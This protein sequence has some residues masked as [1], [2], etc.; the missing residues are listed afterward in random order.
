[1]V[2]GRTKP[3][4]QAGKKAALRTAAVVP[5][6]KSSARF[7]PIVGVGASAGGLEALRRLLKALPAN[8]GM[9]FVLVQHLD[10]EHESMLPRL[11][12][13]ATEMPVLEVQDGM[14]MQPNHVYVIPP[15]TTL[16]IQEN[17]LHLMAR[18]DGGGRHMP[19]DHFFRS[20]AENE[21][22][23]AVGVILSGA[24]S[25]GTLGL[26]TIKAEGGI[27]FAQDERTAK[28]DSMPRSAISAGCV[29]FVLPPEGIARELTRIARHPYLGV[30]APSSAV[31]M[32]GQDNEDL[33]KIF[34]LLRSVTG[35]E[36]T[37]YKYATL[38][39][40]IARRMI[41]HKIV[42]LRNY[43]KYLQENRAE[44]TSLYEDILIHV[45]GFFRNP[46]VFQELKESIFPK[47]L[48]GKP[49]GEPVR[50]WVAGCST[51]EEA[52]SL[53]MVLLEYLGDK[54]PPPPVQIF[55]TDISDPA[56]EK[57]R[58]GIYP[59]SSVSDVS[60]ERLRRF[61]I[62]A[63]GGYQIAKSVREMCV[64]ARQDLAKDPPFSRLDLLS[65]RNVL[66]Y[67]E[68]VLQ[69]KV[70]A[71][72]HYALRPNGFLILGKSESIS[73]FAE[74]FLPAGRNK[75]YS[76][77]PAASRPVFDAPPAG[78]ET[79]PAGSVTRAAPPARFDVQKEADRIVVDH[80]A[81][82]G[83]IANE[84]LQILHFRGDVAPF[85]S[86]APGEASLGLLKMVRPEFAVELRTALHQARKQ[87][88]P[89]R[90]DGVLLKRNGHLFK[91]GLEVVPIKGEAGER[92]YLVLFN[93][94]RVP[95]PGPGAA[96]RTKA[97]KEHELE[98]ARVRRELETNKQHLHS[99]IGEQEA[100]NEELQSANEEIL[101]SN[102]ELQSTNEELETAKEELQSTNEELV[103][104]NEQLQNRN[105]ELGQLSDD[106]S[107]LLGG[108]NIPIVMLGNDR[109]IR[110]FTPP[111]EKLLNLL[112]TDLGRPIDNIRPNF[113]AA[114]MEALI[115]AVI[116]EAAPREQ[117]IAD[118]EGK[119]YSMRL[120][121]YRTADNKIDGV[122]MIFVDV[123]DL[124]RTQVALREQT[125]FAEAVMQ[126]AGALVLVTDSGGRIVAFNRAC[127]LSSGYKLAEVKD[128]SIWDSLL[129][130]KDQLEKLREV[131]R[132]IR[133]GGSPLQHESDWAT[134][135]GE[136]RLISWSSA[137]MA[138][139]DG[140]VRY[141]VWIGS[142]ITERRR[143]EALEANQA[144]LR[145]SQRELRALAAGLI[146]AQEQERKRIS[147][148]LHDDVSQKLVALGMEVEG[149]LRKPN[150]PNRQ[151]RNQLVALRDRLMSV[152]GDIRRTAYQ[153]HPSSLD[154]LG[155]AAALKSY[156]REFARQEGILIH[157]GTRNVPRK[158]PP[159]IALSLYRSAQEALRNVASHSGARRAAVALT[160]RE[161]TL[162]LTVK[163]SGRGFDAARA[164]ARGLGLVSLD[165]RA[166]LIGG[167]FSLKTKPGQGV[168]IDIQ[169]PLPSKR[170]APRGK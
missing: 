11:L 134:R 156:C 53:A 108:V 158:I 65:C 131:Y 110:R 71:I 148:D 162:A 76:K 117:E 91:A 115:A 49:P 44:L 159:H 50:I 123:D 52:Y 62:R 9:A 20:L 39:R 168:R 81:P 31:D 133:P 161:G 1:M 155:L 72:F 25:D 124:K 170:K 4:A 19:I 137:P 103:T 129:I 58:A 83:L 24:A 5:G 136:R 7:Y 43:L 139:S 40:R 118:R 141:V 113:A 28:Y 68:P 47:M 104:V 82:A 48:S 74:W 138:G 107:N 18:R 114:E 30:V 60:G 78:D 23:R 97:G 157:V 151:L 109:R 16:E 54:T 105:L 6:A 13:S 59:E 45:T 38:T 86:P 67:M 84:H 100:T 26:K 37:Y 70:I 42:G 36:F 96:S 51:G 85:L 150:E 10:P 77:K 87:E 69:K 99:I 121:P 21:A 46:D 130:P 75:I 92:Y 15:N 61:F 147:L 164:K 119:W 142:D 3:G 167:A 116:G 125:E 63:D 152:S 98:L 94:Q 169:V 127:E 12:S 66:I 29:D 17:T 143:T 166:R 2:V 153:L 41:L 80:Y 73:G 79:G 135:T 95:E 145:N 35:V 149:L 14:P 101:S 88:A 90:E 32:P 126:T 64:F 27:T 144:A 93:Q 34:L 56:L 146:H 111:A 22:S 8:T 106:L 112:P 160:G 132:K 163:D 102:E 165:E 89:A 122:V 128:R 140:S 33:R 154:H 55:G 57:A 120:R